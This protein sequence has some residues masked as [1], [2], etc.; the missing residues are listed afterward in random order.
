MVNGKIILNMDK[1]SINT[2]MVVSIKD[3][4]KMIKK[5]EMEYLL[6]N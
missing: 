2:L 5:M 6:L 3:N 1:V 4:L